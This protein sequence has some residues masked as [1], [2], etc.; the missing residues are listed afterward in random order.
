MQGITA[1]LILV[2]AMRLKN[3]FGL[4]FG[5]EPTGFINAMDV[6]SKKNQE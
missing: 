1:V 3:G 2:E 5:A 4:C 6:G